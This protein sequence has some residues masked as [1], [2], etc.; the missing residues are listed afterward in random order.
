MHGHFLNYFFRTL[1]E[2]KASLE[3]KIEEYLRTKSEWEVPIPKGT[4]AYS[5]A[6]RAEYVERNLD[7]AVKYYKISI[8]NNERVESAIKDLATVLHQ[9]GIEIF[10]FTQVAVIF[11][12]K[13]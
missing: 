10:C 2:L 5:K 7:K 9:Q 4:S 3:T 13:N 8:E 6:K 1:K 11:D 12:R